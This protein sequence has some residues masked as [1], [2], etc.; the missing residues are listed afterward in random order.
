MKKAAQLKESFPL[1][2]HNLDRKRIHR[3]NLVNQ[4]ECNLAFDQSSADVSGAD[5]NSASGEAMHLNNHLFVLGD[6]IRFKKLI[7]NRQNQL[8][9]RLNRTALE[10]ALSPKLRKRISDSIFDRQLKKTASRRHSSNILRSNHTVDESSS[11][12]ESEYTQHFENELV[13]AK[14]DFGWAVV[15]RNRLYFILTTPSFKN[16]LNR[17]LDRGKSADS[18]HQ[19]KQH[20]SG[21]RILGAQNHAFI[22]REHSGLDGGGPAQNC[23]QNDRGLL[24]GSENENILYL[25]K[26]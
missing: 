6:T 18:R 13:H 22:D 3:L 23:G 25:Q 9:H 5:L 14:T 26:A 8:E 20:F 10:G 16:R 1:E 12:S 19:T 4:F 24:F 17:R 21:V 15:D 2:P 7:R 11:E